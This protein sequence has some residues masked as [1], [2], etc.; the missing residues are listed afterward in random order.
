[1]IQHGINDIIHP[2][3]IETN[4]FRPWSDLPKAKEMTDAFMRLYIEEA[5][6]RGLRVWGGTLLPIAGWRTYAEF[7]DDLRNEF[8]DWLRQ[9]SRLD[10]CVDFD[11]ALRD[12]AHPERFRKE[13]DSGDHLHPS[14]EG[15]RA[16]ADCVPEELLR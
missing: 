11:K 1:M 14:K 4:I 8:N 13:Y 6:R 5:K 7:R 10:G 12:E 3:G 15:Y 16:M 9:C 2:V